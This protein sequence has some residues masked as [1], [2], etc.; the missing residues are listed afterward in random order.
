MADDKEKEPPVPRWH[1]ETRGDKNRRKHKE[2][3]EKT[4]EKKQAS[5]PRASADGPPIAYEP[6]DFD[7]ERVRCAC[8]RTTFALC[9]VD[10]RGVPAA[11]RGDAEEV[12]DGCWTAWVRE[13][14]LSRAE[15]A[16][17]QGA[18]PEVVKHIRDHGHPHLP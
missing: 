4:S 17:Y 14:K 1:P 7:L 12:C 8:G 18:P 6:D 2:A 5:E 16:G 3:N 10:V 9:M 13:E 15:L 11:I